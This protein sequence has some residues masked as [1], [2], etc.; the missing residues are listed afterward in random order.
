MAKIPY[1][2]IVVGLVVTVLGGLI[3]AL[4]LLIVKMIW[5]AAFSSRS[6]SRAKKV[7]LHAQSR[8]EFGE[9]VV[10]I[11]FHNDT[12]DIY[13]LQSAWLSGIKLPVKKVAIKPHD[14]S[15]QSVTTKKY[16]FSQPDITFSFRVSRGG[17]TYQIHQKCNTYPNVDNSK[18][19]L[20]SIDPEV[21]AVKA[22]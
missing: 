4:I 16:S 21:E 15:Y 1:D 7:E 6:S 13:V 9:G 11:D 12:S 10:A 22:V 5:V 18:F 8:S 20:A 2:Q 17:K 14:A 19:F 3:L